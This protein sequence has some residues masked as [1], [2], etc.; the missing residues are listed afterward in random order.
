MSMTVN[1]PDEMKVTEGYAVADELM[2]KLQA[3][4]G[5][6]TVGIMSGGG[7]GDM[8]LSSGSNKDFTFFLLLDDETGK[9]NTKVAKKLEKDDGR[10]S[11]GRIKCCNLNMDMSALTGDGLTLNIYGDDLD[12][13]LSVS[14]DMK[15][16]LSGIE[17]FENIENG[18]SDGD[19]QLVITVDK[20]KAMRL[21]G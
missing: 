16:L 21:R 6:E 9:N 8:M 5:I 13:L 15:N 10:L 2:E 1:M 19:R 3:V 20:D 17:G 14:E 4:Q 11:T 18:Q 7:S 12:T